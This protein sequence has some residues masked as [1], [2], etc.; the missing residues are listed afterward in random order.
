MYTR[1]CGARRLNE[2][3]TRNAGRAHGFD[4]CIEQPGGFYCP[5]IDPVSQKRH[6]F[7]DAD[8]FTLLAKFN[9]VAGQR[10]NPCWTA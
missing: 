4:E 7:N 2:I 8:K 5:D 9:S 3:M 10:A 1:Y 6:R